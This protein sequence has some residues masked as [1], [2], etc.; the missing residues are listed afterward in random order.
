MASISN[1]KTQDAKKSQDTENTT[2]AEWLD[3]VND[4]YA[5]FASC[6]EEIGVEKLSDIGRGFEAEMLVEL[7][8]FIRAAGGKSMHVKIVKTAIVEFGQQETGAVIVSAIRPDI[9]APSAHSPKK[10]FHQAA[11][12]YAAF[13]SHHKASCAMEAR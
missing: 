13:L 7:E 3:S 4:G 8:A 12:K 1:H 11:K 9:P 5:R 6:F 10:N 2:V